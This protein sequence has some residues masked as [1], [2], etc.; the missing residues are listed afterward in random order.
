MDRVIGLDKVLTAVIEGAIAKYD[1]EPAQCEIAGVDAADAV[2]RKAQPGAIVVPLP[3]MSKQYYAGRYGLVNFRKRPRFCLP[4]VPAEAA[5]GY[6]VR[7]EG[8]FHIQA[9]T[10]LRSYLQWMRLKVGSCRDPGEVLFYG[11]GV[12][13]HVRVVHPRENAH[14][15]RLAQRSPV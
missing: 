8:L 4:V 15:A 11:I 7:R 9:K 6:D 10:V 2:G 12:N 14:H 5:I 3:E 1:S 13:A